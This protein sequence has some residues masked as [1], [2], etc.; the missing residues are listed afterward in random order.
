M[1]RETRRRDTM[2]QYLVRHGAGLTAV[3]TVPQLARLANV[4]GRD[5]ERLEY[6][7]EEDGED[8]RPL[9]D[10]EYIELAYLRCA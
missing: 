10:E 1:K 2:K 8:D 7:V 4:L 6:W 3:D 9:S 5:N